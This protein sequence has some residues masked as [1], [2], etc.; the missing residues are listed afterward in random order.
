LLS[1]RD[2]Y[3]YLPASVAYL[4]VEA[5]LREMLSSAG[6]RAIE[7]RR[8]SAGVAQLVTARRADGRGEM[9]G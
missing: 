3:S 7:K 1:D 6:F 4:P 9:L 8:L 2:A 5:A